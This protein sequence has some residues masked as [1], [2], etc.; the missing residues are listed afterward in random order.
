[1]NYL[2]QQK[3]VVLSGGDSGDGSDILF[4]FFPF[5]LYLIPLCKGHACERQEQKKVGHF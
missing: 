4:Y 3:F 1:M 2:N 5:K